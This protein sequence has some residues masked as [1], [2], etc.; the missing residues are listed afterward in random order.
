MGAL[1]DRIKLSLLVNGNGI[2]E[3]YRN[4]TNYFTNKYKSSEKDIL[5]INLRDIQKGRFYF[6]HY[7]DVSGSNWMRFSPVFV[8]DYKV[9]NGEVLIFAVNLNF[10]P[11]EIR[12]IIFDTFYNE[13]MLDKDSYVNIDFRTVYDA[14]FKVGYEY[15]IMEY[16][17]KSIDI[18]HKISTVVLPRFLYS[19]HSLNKYDPKKLYSIWKAKLGGRKQRHEEILKLSALDLMGIS[20]NINENFDILKK[21][22]N[23][24]KKNFE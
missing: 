13:Q 7:K 10:I 14:L 11:I 15:A 2:I 20:D 5:N 12:P 9:L 6:F 17:I 22:I 24:V 8:C 23:R 16:N 21:H 19:G 1:L 3:N 18:V 4:N